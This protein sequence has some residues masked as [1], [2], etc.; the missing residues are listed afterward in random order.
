MPTE[1][2]DP[3]MR[4]RLRIFFALLCALVAAAPALAANKPAKER[5]ATPAMW[6]VH[7][8]KGTVYM[9]GSIHALPKNI[10]WQTPELMARVQQADTFVFE[11]PMNPEARAKAAQYFRENAVLPA[12]LSLPSMFDAEMRGEFRDVV[13]LTNADPTYIV[14]MRPW[15]A[16]LVLEGAASG[17]TGMYSSEGVDNKIYA[18]ARKRGVTQFRA[19]ERDEDQFR[20]F[21]K[22]G[23]V[24]EEIADLRITFKDIIAHRGADGKGLLTAWMKGDTKALARTVP[25]D[26]ATSAKFRKEVI[27][28]R[29]RKWVPEIEAM[30]NE[31]HTFFITVGAAHLVGKTGV[32]NLLR[33]AGYKV[34]GP[35]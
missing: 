1:F 12:G 13:M 21:I 6:A 2:G 24:E 25:E 28:D 17:E 18:M 3:A 11:V 19:L 35:A 15:L 23:H 16:A 34:E 33:A 4:V 31:N 8:A 32:P 5:P 30:L 9:L 20:L 26:K 7:G 10:H 29:N 27:E 22:E 14:Y